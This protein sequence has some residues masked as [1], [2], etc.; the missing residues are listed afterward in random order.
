MM[1]NIRY[2]SY[3]TGCCRSIEHPSVAVNVLV[4]ERLQPLLIT[5]PS[6]DV[7]VTAPHVSCSSST[8]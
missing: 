1:D 4:L 5:A 3:S 8:K 6:D 2:P 7:I